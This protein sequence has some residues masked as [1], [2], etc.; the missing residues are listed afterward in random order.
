M[1]GGLNPSQ[2]LSSVHGKGWRSR[3]AL[4]TRFSRVRRLFQTTRVAESHC[5]LKAHLVSNFTLPG[6]WS[7][8]TAVLQLYPYLLN[9]V[10]FHIIF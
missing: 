5:K 10:L 6:K 8:I 1:V 9:V 2:L 7:P 4:P 3:L